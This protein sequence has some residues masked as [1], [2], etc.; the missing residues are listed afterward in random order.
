MKSTIFLLVMSVSIS[1]YA[2]TMTTTNS[3][4]AARYLAGCGFDYE[5]DSTGNKINNVP[6]APK[7]INNDPN[8]VD[9][10]GGSHTVG[11]IDKKNNDLPSLKQ[12]EMPKVPVS[13]KR[14][15]YGIDYAEPK[16]KPVSV[17]PKMPSVQPEKE[18]QVK[19]E[20]SV[21]PPYQPWL[22]KEK[23]VEN[24]DQQKSEPKPIAPRTKATPATQ[25]DTQAVD[26]NLPTGPSIKTKEMPLP[27]QE[28]LNVD[29]EVT[30]PVKPTMDRAAGA[31]EIFETHEGNAIKKSKPLNER[32]GR[33]TK[34]LKEDDWKY[35]ERDES[36]EEEKTRDQQ[37]EADKSKAKKQ[38]PKKQEEPEQKT[39]IKKFDPNKKIEF[40]PIYEKSES[41]KK[42]KKLDPNKWKSFKKDP[43][44]SDRS[45]DSIYERKT[46]STSSG[47]SRRG[48]S[49]YGGESDIALQKQAIANK[50]ARI[51]REQAKKDADAAFMAGMLTDTMMNAAIGHIDAKNAKK[52][53]GSS[54]SSSEPT[55]YRSRGYA[56]TVYSRDEDSYSAP[57]PN[58]SATYNKAK[59]MTGGG[60]W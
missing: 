31:H 56:D 36:I 59:S 24:K 40:K 37:Q 60:G 16:T 14:T 13:D 26:P 55:V 12:K 58:N 9:L 35:P 49:S 57:N 1:A 34:P 44:S 45:L 25:K 21:M 47:R 27:G 42:I 19:S 50:E 29:K 5:C 54:T 15:G 3:A 30:Q 28:P 48:A 20:D 10:G 52:S 17:L 51:A 41:A 23:T 53:G 18:A 8:T 38:K 22:K 32:A 33:W 39:V 11:I 46:S 7:V 43:F 4:T 2:Q 6:T